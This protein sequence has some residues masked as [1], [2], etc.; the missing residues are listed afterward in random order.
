MRLNWINKWTVDRTTIHRLL[1]VSWDALLIK[2]F[3]FSTRLRLC[4]L[5]KTH[6]VSWNVKWNFN[7]IRID[8]ILNSSS[9]LVCFK[10]TEPVSRDIDRE[11]RSYMRQDLVFRFS[12]D[13]RIVRTRCCKTIYSGYC[14]GPDQVSMTIGPLLLGTWIFTVQKWVCEFFSNF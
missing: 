9:W 13:A 14:Q 7:L 2:F 10:F 8:Y 12:S 5:V 6:V 4:G 1:Y 3:A 11:T